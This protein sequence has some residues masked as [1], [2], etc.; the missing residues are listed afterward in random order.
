MA[1]KKKAGPKK[2]VKRKSASRNPRSSKAAAKKPA[3]RARGVK[4]S[5]AKRAAGRKRVQ[6]VRAAVKEKARQGLDVA[7]EGLERIKQTTVNL[8]DEVKQRIGARDE[9]P[10]AGVA[11]TGLEAEHMR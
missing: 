2:A 3:A 10:D 7:R 6:R 8:V 1:R 9:G 4:K 5:T 11:E